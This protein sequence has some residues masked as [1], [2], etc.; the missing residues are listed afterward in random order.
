MKEV[1]KEI[2]G[3][4]GI[5]LISNL[6]NV[7]SLERFVSNHSGFNKKLKE[8]YRKPSISKTGY[9]V[10]D[11]QKESKRKTFKLH[12]LI[13]IAFI[14][15]T[16][17]KPCINHKN[18]N[19]LDNRI[20]NLEWC[21]ISEN[22]IHAINTKLKNDSGVNN[23]KSNITENDVYF[24]RNSKLKLKELSEMFNINQ[25]GISKIKLRKTYKCH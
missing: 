9:Y 13:A 2:N 10:L 1:W 18:G 16:F 24:I 25:S 4:E 22:N 8:K 3:Y 17:N 12:R 14:E 15:N 11:L 23:S 21:T 20:E 6:G 5:Y 7:K 19:K